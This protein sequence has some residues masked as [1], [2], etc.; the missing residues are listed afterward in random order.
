MI[1]CND[2]L[3]VAVTTNGCINTIDKNMV[4]VSRSYD[5]KHTI[6][7]THYHDGLFVMSCLYGGVIVGDGF[8]WDYIDTGQNEHLNYVDNLNDLWISVGY[9]SSVVTS[10]DGRYW[11]TSEI[12]GV[13]SEEG[14]RAKPTYRLNS[15]AYGNGLFVVVGSN[16]IIAT[17]KDAINWTMSIVTASDLISVVYNDGLFV[18]SGYNGFVLVSDGTEEWTK[19]DIG[20]IKKLNNLFFLKDRF[21]LVGSGGL[22]LT[23]FDGLSW[24]KKIIKGETSL[25]S[26][27]YNN[28]VFVIA[29]V[30]SVYTSRK[31]LM[32]RGCRD[33]VGYIG[34]VKAF[35][36]HFLSMTLNGLNVF[37]SAPNGRGWSKI[38][39]IGV[40][41][42]DIY[43]R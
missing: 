29:G 38:D 27:A 32:W 26:A 34:D 31:C 10:K 40:E 20:S 6:A 16:G 41:G 2:D 24:K 7:D 18:V 25:K 22:L 43:G 21:V 15:I 5:F 11:V 17:S 8:R 39:L 33:T 3:A 35:G 30:D 36:N 19:I 4:V 1:A 9:D 23:S 12:D 14:C 37:K 42:R 28:G 13:R